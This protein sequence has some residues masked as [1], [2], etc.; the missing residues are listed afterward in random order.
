[1]LRGDVSSSSYS[2]ANASSAGGLVGRN[3]SATIEN[4]YATGDVS[5]SSAAAD[6]SSY[7]AGLVV[8]IM[9]VI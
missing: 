5:S 8:I 3:R 9:M 1:M 6:S 4:S 2:S 7:A